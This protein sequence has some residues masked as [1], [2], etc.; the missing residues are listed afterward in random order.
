MK[1][2]Y[3]VVLLF[4]VSISLPA[5]PLSNSAFSVASVNTNVNSLSLGNATVSLRGAYGDHHINPAGIGMKNTSSFSFTNNSVVNYGNKH[6]AFASVIGL[7]KI[8]FSFSVTKF[9]SGESGPHLYF[10]DQILYSRFNSAELYSNVS[11]A[12]SLSSHLRVGLGINHLHATSGTGSLWS[13]Q[14]TGSLQ[15]LSLDAGMQYENEFSANEDLFIT[16]SFGF[17]ITDFGNGVDYHRPNYKV[18]LPT[19]AR[20][21]FGISLKS[22]QKIFSRNLLRLTLTGDI[23]KAL[24]RKEKVIS[25]TDTSYQ[26]MSPFD[27]L[28]KT[29]DDF[30]F[31]NGQRLT[32]YNVW[33]Q[34]RFHAG[35]EITILESFMLRWGFQHMP[36]YEDILTYQSLGIGIDFFYLKFNSN[37]ILG[38]DE[39]HKFSFIY[40]KH[41]QLT[42]RI[43][44]N[45]EK[46]DTILN[47]IFK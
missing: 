3:L 28:I 29:W 34:L 46:P 37:F 10:S 8:F 4:M 30:D 13:I 42:G 7:E 31:N 47:H 44:L 41:W 15:A 17:S 32:N 27:Q 35:I 23:S 22:G 11:L 43:P 21:G 2:V 12:Y 33:E 26:A 40:G 6:Q 25:A 24:G 45:G 19:I 20:S 1:S 18:P 36:E 14:K 9:K 39:N 16:P 5:Q 38:P